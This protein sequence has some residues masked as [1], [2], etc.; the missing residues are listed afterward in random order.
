MPESKPWVGGTSVEESGI[1][2]SEMEEEEILET[3]PEESTEDK[4]AKELMESM[5][6]LSQDEV[7]RK[8]IGLM[9]V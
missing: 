3:V 9:L 6:R 4:V 1:P 2:L 8:K 7:L 5:I